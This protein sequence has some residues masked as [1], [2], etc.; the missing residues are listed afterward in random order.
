MFLFFFCYNPSRNIDAFNSY[1]L[2]FPE[3]NVLQYILDTGRIQ[4]THDMQWRVKKTVDNRC[5]Y[6]FF[7]HHQKKMDFSVEFGRCHLKNIALCI[8]M[9]V[10][11]NKDS[12]WDTRN[13]EMYLYILYEMYEIIDI[14][15]VKA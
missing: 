7:R 14:L 12:F 15:C 9:I 1:V 3:G 8:G 4:D 10:T 13:G 2:C 6:F 5:C 11:E